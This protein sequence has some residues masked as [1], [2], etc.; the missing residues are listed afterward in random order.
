MKAHIFLIIGSEV[1]RKVG[2][3]STTPATSYI[4]DNYRRGRHLGNDIKQKASCFYNGTTDL[5]KAGHL[6]NFPDS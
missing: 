1:Y 3:S 2:S 6:F 4:S 5:S